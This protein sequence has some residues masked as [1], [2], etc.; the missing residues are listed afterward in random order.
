V[1]AAFSLVVSLTVEQYK[2]FLPKMEA[3][4]K[5]EGY[6]LRQAICKIHPAG[7][8]LRY[9]Y[10]SKDSNRPTLLISAEIV[11]VELVPDSVLAQSA[12]YWA[13]ASKVPFGS[14]KAEVSNIRE[15]RGS[16]RIVVPYAVCYISSNAKMRNLAEQQTSLNKL[17]KLVSYELGTKLKATMQNKQ[18]ITMEFYAAK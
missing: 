10:S 12:A 13:P 17:A 9:Q 11:P 7:G 2:P 3:E 6:Q 16:I 4:L 1:I 18:S 5:R 14:K 15:N 8:V